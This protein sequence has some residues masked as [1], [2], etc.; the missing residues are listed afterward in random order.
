MSPTDHTRWLPPRM[1]PRLNLLETGA[2]PGAK[3]NR[4]PGRWWSTLSGD[5]LQVP[6]GAAT[7]QGARA[8]VGLLVRPLRAKRLANAV[9]T[10]AIPAG[11]ATVT[12]APV[13]WGTRHVSAAAR[14]QLHGRVAA[15]WRSHQIAIAMSSI[16][17]VGAPAI[18]AGLR[19]DPQG[20]YRNT[21]ATT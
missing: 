19:S 12:D 14:R 5:S 7:T 9:A 15:N 1:S 8:P 2:S 3:S 17:E 18:H 6:T 11:A 10:L 4:A 20:R 21:S 13:S 16:A